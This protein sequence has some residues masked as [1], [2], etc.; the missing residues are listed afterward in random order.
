ME[1]KARKTLRKEI[2]KCRFSWV[3]GSYD[4]A[5]LFKIV[6]IYKKISNLIDKKGLGLHRDDGLSNYDN[7]SGPEIE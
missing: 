4:W 7:L 1:F 3:R 5:R 2:W 6:V